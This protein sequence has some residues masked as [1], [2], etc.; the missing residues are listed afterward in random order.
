M[1]DLIKR[2]LKFYENNEINDYIY[3]FYATSGFC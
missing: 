1:F 3:Y 2:I